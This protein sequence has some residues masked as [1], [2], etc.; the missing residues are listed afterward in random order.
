MFKKIFKLIIFSISL[1]LIRKFDQEDNM[2]LN[3]LGEIAKF[4]TNINDALK[5][6]N[7]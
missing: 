5:F 1:Q 6:F 2:E 3:V 7:C 4:W